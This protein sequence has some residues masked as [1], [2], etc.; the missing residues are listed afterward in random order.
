MGK[1][2]WRSW[3]SPPFSCL[4]RLVVRL[5]SQGCQVC[6][7]KIQRVEGL[8]QRWPVMPRFRGSTEFTS[9]GPGPLEDA[10]HAGDAGEVMEK[11]MS[12]A[13]WISLLQP[14]RLPREALHVMAPERCTHVQGP[15]CVGVGVGV[16]VGVEEG[17]GGEGIEMSRSVSIP[18]RNSLSGDQR[19]GESR[20]GGICGCRS[21]SSSRQDA[22]V[23]V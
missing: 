15:R 23:T 1:L 14:G 17:A 16:G 21:C 22:S 8:T 9:H 13:A 11:A 3:H 7:L 2:D 12:L 20:V 10:A 18:R 6:T 19:N 4:M 5:Q